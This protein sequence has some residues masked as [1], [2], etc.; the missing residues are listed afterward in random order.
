MNRT[1]RQSY[2]SMR[3]LPRSAGFV[4]GNVQGWDWRSHLG[5]KPMGRV[6]VSGGRAFSEAIQQAKQARRERKR[7][8]REAKAKRNRG[9]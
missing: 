9:K 8:A 5:V 3:I 4:L 1:D 2:P 6:K 7:K